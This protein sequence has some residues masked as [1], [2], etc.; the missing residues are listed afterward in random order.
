MAL[1]LIRHHFK[2]DKNPEHQAL[3]VE[4]QYCCQV[5]IVY[6]RIKTICK[7]VIVPKFS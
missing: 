1:A 4:L 5:G 2:D 3:I 7:V 6:I